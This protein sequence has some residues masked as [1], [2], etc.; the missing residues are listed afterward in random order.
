MIV[1]DALP[2]V[3]DSS[4]TRP[5]A[6][7]DEWAILWEGLSTGNNCGTVLRQTDVHGERVYAGKVPP[8]RLELPAQGLGI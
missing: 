6:D 3:W 4:V 2:H 7:E 5:L 1:I 8:G